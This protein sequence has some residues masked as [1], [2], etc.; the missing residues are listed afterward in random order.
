MG[1]LTNRTIGVVVSVVV[2]LIGLTGLTFP[3]W[4]DSVESP[5]APMVVGLVLLVITPMEAPR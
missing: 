3:L 4:S 5:V 1:F 2:G